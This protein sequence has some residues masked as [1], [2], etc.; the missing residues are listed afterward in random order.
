MTP[1]QLAAPTGIGDLLDPDAVQGS[2]FTGPLISGSPDD[3]VPGIAL[4]HKR[5]KITVSNGNF[6]IPIRFPPSSILMQVVVQLQQTYNGATP[7]VNLGTTPNGTDIASVDVSVAPTQVF[8]NI[9]TIL[10]SSWTIYLSQVVSA[11]TNGKC[12]VLI[13]YSVPAKTIFS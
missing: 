9:T 6:S 7:K 13:T 8:N 5:A 3:G 11:A 4:L 2:H 12:T 1:T 10:G